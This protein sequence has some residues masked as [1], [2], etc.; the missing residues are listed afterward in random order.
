VIALGVADLAS[1]VGGTLAGAD[2]AAVVSAPATVD[3]RDVAPGGLFVAFAGER[4]DGHD[5]VAAAI[6]AG[7]TVALTS[8]AVEGSPCVVVEDQQVALGKLARYVLDRLPDLTVIGLTG[9]QGKTSTKDL[10][11]QLLR[12]SGATVAPR[13]SQNNEIGH[14]VTALKCTAE[15]RFL[16]AEMGARH[17]GDIAYLTGITPPRVGLVLNVGSSHI[18]EFGSREAIAQAKGELVEAL[19]ADGTAVLNADDPLVAAMAGRTKAGVLTFGEADSADVRATGVALDENGR[20]GF[21]LH[22]G[23]SEHPVRLKLVGEHQVSNALAAAA[24]AHAVRIDAGDIA[25][26]LA[27]AGAESRWRMEVTDRADG[28]T[29]INDAYNANPDSMR[30]ALKALVAIGRAR[31]AR[32]WAVLGEM[33]ELGAASAAEHDAVGRLAVR[34][35]VN[36]LVA[37]G[38]AARAIHLGAAHEGSWGDESVYAEDAGAALDLLRH[39]LRPGDVVLVKAS[40][41]VGLETLAAALIADAPTKE[42][43]A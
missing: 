12:P 39:E 1:A 34:L 30:A 7:A 37:V 35:D 24:V 3:S 4:V 6:A 31:D 22:V 25:A 5:Y 42:A 40:R 27:E 9:S 29:V 11:A 14:P 26:R 8:R 13:G 17:V 23:G 20:P 18:G 15:T 43:T 33:R 16:V 28:V 32:T 36:R 21:T 2:P 10:I 38:E 19:P 41:A